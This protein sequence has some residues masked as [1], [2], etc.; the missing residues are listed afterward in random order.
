MDSVGDHPYRWGC[1]IPEIRGSKSARLSPRLIA[2]CYVLHRLSVPRHPPNALKTLDPDRRTPTLVSVVAILEQSGATLNRDNRHRYYSVKTLKPP[3]AQPARIP[4][5]S[6][7]NQPGPKPNRDAR[8]LYLGHT[9]IFTMSK[10]HELRHPAMPGARP[11]AC[12]TG[13]G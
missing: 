6:R 1:P 9:H 7:T 3:D 12:R 11:E 13:S 2:A 8:G 10:H 5:L 4:N